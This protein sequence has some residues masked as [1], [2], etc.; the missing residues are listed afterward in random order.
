MAL[1]PETIVRHELNGLCV[2]VVEAAN[3][4]LIG[5][6]GRVVAETTNTL[7]IECTQRDEDQVKQV[8]KVGAVFEFVLTDDAAIAEKAVGS[9][10]KR[11]CSC[12][13]VAYVT[14]DGARL[15]SRP[16]RRSEQRGISPWQ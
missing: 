8:P 7:H 15:L 6:E 16:A 4:D 5:I 14:V 13:D 9:T 3:A 10:S 2:R 12:D 11:E 1:T